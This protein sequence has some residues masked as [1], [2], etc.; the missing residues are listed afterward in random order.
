LFSR[1]Y[2]TPTHEIGSKKGEF[3]TDFVGTIEEIV[4][5]ILQQLMQLFTVPNPIGDKTHQIKVHNFE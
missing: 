3:R 4:M 1:V 2:I 5:M